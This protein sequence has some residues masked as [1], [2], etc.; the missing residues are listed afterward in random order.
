MF[1]VGVKR[2]EWWFR[3]SVFFASAVFLVWFLLIVVSPNAVPA[4]SC[5]D[6]SGTVGVSDNADVFSGF[7]QPWGLVY[8]VGDR[9]CH[10]RADRSFFLGGNELPFCARC[11][12]V[13]LGLFLGLVVMA[14]VAVPLDSRLAWV[15]VVGLLPLMVDGGGQLLGLWESTNVVRLVTGVLAGVVGGLGIGI[16]VTEFADV[17]R[18][19]PV[20]ED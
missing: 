14:F 4:G 17:V 10:Q 1:V 5:Q 9:L 11:T 20:K 12:G 16:L 13:W 6:L 15:F 18:K 7:P 19:K 3:P 8:S 2:V